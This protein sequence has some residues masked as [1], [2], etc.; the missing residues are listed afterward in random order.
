MPIPDPPKPVPERP[1]A[2]GTNGPDVDILQAVLIRL[3]FLDPS[4]VNKWR[5]HFGPRT[6]EA[7]VNYQLRRVCMHGCETT[8][9]IGEVNSQS[10]HLLRL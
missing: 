9:T 3:G 2:I 8:D 4:A 6:R 1:L 7:V 10:D 5:G